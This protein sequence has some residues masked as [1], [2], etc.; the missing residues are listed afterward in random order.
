MSAGKT[1]LFSG[2]PLI[3]I[4]MLRALFGSVTTSAASVWLLDSKLFNCLADASLF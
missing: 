1:L 4:T 3:V 2:M